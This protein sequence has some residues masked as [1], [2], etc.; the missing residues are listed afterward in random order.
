VQT[1]QYA[2]NVLVLVQRPARTGIILACE[3]RRLSG[4]CATISILEAQWLETIP[5]AINHSRIQCRTGKIT[6]QYAKFIVWREREKKTF[7]LCQNKL[8]WKKYSIVV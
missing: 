4:S 2:K 5:G 3:I 1:V 7:C 6:A 8:S